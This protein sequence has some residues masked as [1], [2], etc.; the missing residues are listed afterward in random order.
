MAL[1]K[2][3]TATLLS[4][5]SINMPH[6]TLAY[7]SINHQQ[8]AQRTSLL[9]LSTTTT[10]RQLVQTAGSS[11][12]DASCFYNKDALSIA[13]STAIML[14]M[15]ASSGVGMLLV[16]LQLLPLRTARCCKCPG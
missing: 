6:L 14:G 15:E 5:N 11:T 8:R 10:S 13:K 9:L 7:L 4:M 1:C 3:Q 2:A 16:L 12:S